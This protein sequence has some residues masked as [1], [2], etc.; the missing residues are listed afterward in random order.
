[1][2]PT[3]AEHFLGPSYGELELVHPDYSKLSIPIGHGGFG[4]FCATAK[5]LACLYLP[6]R[7]DPADSAGDVQIT[8]ISPRDGVIELLRYSFSPQIAEALGLAGRRLDIF[9]KLVQQVPLRRLRYPSGLD[10]LPQTREAVL[11]DLNAVL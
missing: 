6:E 11:A 4:A 9:T 7:D 8:P 10:R 2:W 5:P 3:T 1:M